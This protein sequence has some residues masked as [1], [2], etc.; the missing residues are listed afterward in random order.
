[1]LEILRNVH[2]QFVYGQ[3]RDVELV[4]IRA[5]PLQ[6][7][8]K[9]LYFPAIRH[10]LSQGTRR[11]ILVR[12]LGHESSP[13]RQLLFQFVNSVMSGRVQ[14][15]PL[16]FLVIVK[17]RIRVVSLAVLT[18]EPDHLLEQESQYFV[19]WLHLDLIV[20]NHTLVPISLKILLRHPI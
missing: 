4:D 16:M 11:A 1:M 17:F 8:H 12:F 2:L 7:V 18:I 13:A 9:S 14:L 10:G 6:N 3:V 15:T 19:G 5:V 20:T